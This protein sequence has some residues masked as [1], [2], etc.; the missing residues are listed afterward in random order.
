MLRNEGYLMQACL[1]NAN[2]T[3]VLCRVRTTNSESVKTDQR[4]TRRGSILRDFEAGPSRKSQL[5]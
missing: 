1:A 5:I 4:T 3:T 2:A